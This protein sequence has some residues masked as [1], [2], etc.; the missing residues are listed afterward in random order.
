MQR[1]YEE[2]EQSR[3]RGAGSMG[4]AAPGRG[5]HSGKPIANGRGGYNPPQPQYSTGANRGPAVANGAQ[6]G[7]GYTRDARAGASYQQRVPYMQATPAQHVA[8]VAPTGY[9]QQCVPI[10]QSLL[11]LKCAECYVVT[12]TQHRSLRLC[13]T[14][15]IALRP[16]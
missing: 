13:W 4:N 8:P 11:L 5:Y 10:P 15:S 3:A 9:L 14:C 1:E 7:G 6:G 16:P 2:L 12:L